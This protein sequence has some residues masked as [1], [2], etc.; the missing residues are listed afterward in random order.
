[1]SI[2]DA[3]N[4]DEGIKRQKFMCKATGLLKEEWIQ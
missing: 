1:M 2:D 3:M 4:K